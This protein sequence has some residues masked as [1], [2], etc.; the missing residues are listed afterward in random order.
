MHYH[1]YIS[2]LAVGLLLAW[3]PI[4]AKEQV[5]RH[6]IEFPAGRERTYIKGVISSQR[7]IDYTLSADAGQLLSVTLYS[8]DEDN[9]FDLLLPYSKEP[10]FTSTISGNQLNTQLPIKGD[11]T[12]RLYHSGQQNDPTAHSHYQL[13][14][15]KPE[16]ASRPR[17][18]SAQG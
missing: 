13:R 1:R 7:I 9:H 4:Q 12:L 2:A 3:Q 11:Y 16:H 6:T 5:E 18:A 14:I 17:A 15:Y 10:L 8:D